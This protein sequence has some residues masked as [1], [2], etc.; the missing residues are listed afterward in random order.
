MLDID[1]R[2]LDF[3]RDDECPRLDVHPAHGSRAAVVRVSKASKVAKKRR[4][5]EDAVRVDRRT[6]LA[7]HVQARFDD[8]LVFDPDGSSWSPEFAARIDEDDWLPEPTRVSA[9]L[10]ESTYLAVSRDVPRQFTTI[11]DFVHNDYGDI[12]PRHIHHALREL[13]DHRKVASL[14][15]PWWSPEQQRREKC[16]GFYV[17]YDSPA[18]WRGDLRWLLSSVAEQAQEKRS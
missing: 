10:L 13:I 14:A 1:L 11:C 16:P 4:A 2:S 6:A 5:D 7:A 3:C 18:I 17:R 12:V 8:A 9:G 15:H